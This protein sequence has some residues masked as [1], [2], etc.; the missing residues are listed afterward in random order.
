MCDAVSVGR[1]ELSK[2]QDWSL[3]AAEALYQLVLP[4]LM[5]LV[6]TLRLDANVLRDSTLQRLELLHM[7]AYLHVSATTWIVCFEELRRL[8]NS[9]KV[10]II[11]PELNRVYDRLCDVGTLLQGPNALDILVIPY[12]SFHFC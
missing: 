3:E 9:K 1:A 8:T 12:P 2:R 11:P 5:Y 10:E 4:L 6:K 7:E